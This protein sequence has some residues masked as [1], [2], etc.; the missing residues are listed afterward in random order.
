[1]LVRFREVDPFNCWIWIHFA[2]V[3]GQG[4]QNYIDGVFDSWYVIG[5][6]GGF[7]AESLQVQEEG[8]ELSWMSYDSEESGSVIPAL[9][10]NVGQLEYQ[11][12]WARC[13]VDLGTSD[14]LA[15]DV[16]INTLN[17]I[18]KDLVQIEELLI[19]GVNDDWQVEEHPDAI[20]TD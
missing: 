10:H 15:I 12:E 5:R 7:N 11:G 16:L 13:W 6:L 17:Q 8:S 14:A 2:N 20:F 1:M 4:E 18:D 19:G 9:M 3:P